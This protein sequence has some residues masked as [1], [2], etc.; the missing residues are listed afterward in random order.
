LNYEN[1]PSEA[2]EEAKRFLLDSVGC[3]FSALDNKDIQAAYK[4][5]RLASSKAARNIFIF[6]SK[7][8]LAHF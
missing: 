2:L 7:A 5:N 3:A 8:N 6:G 1:I 4:R